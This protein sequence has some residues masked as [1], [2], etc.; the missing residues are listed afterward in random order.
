MTGDTVIFE[1]IKRL[2]ATLPLEEQVHVLQ[3]LLASASAE[4]MALQAKIEHGAIARVQHKKLI[5]QQQSG[6]TYRIIGCAL[7]AHSQLG[8]GLREASHQ[9]ALAFS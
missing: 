5:N 7:A 2:L 4:T 3:Q 8:G 1:A 9:Q 6:L